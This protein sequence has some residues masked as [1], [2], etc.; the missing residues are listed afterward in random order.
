MADDPV[1]RL[2]K[3]TAGNDTEQLVAPIEEN[4]EPN[5]DEPQHQRSQEEGLSPVLILSSGSN[6]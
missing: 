1:R 5:R 3:A 6:H 4:F 2:V